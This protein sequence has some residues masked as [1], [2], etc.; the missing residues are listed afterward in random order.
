MIT[1]IF[2]DYWLP[3]ETNAT[4][5]PHTL[6]CQALWKPRA[7]ITYS[8]AR[9]P[10]KSPVHLGMEQQA[11]ASSWESLHVTWRNNVYIRG[12]RTFPVKMSHASGG[13]LMRNYIF[14]SLICRCVAFAKQ[15]MKWAKAQKQCVIATPWHWSRLWYA[16]RSLPTWQSPARDTAG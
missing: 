5:S 6:D 15:I 1:L 10:I 13:T 11:A 7:A 9:V 16:L 14:Y 12:P 8:C 4:Q 2:C 3:V